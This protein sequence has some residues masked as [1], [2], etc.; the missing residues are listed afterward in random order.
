M[1]ALVEIL[2]DENYLTTVIAVGIGYDE[3]NDDRI[4]YYVDSMED[5]EALKYE[6]VEDFVVTDIFNTAENI[7][8]L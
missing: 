7:D 4:F 1:Y 5:L 2:Q 3:K 8:E 6:G